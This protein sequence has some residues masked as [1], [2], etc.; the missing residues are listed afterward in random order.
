MKRLSRDP[1]RFDLI[2]VFAEYGRE[3]KVSL[4]N[5]NAAA[6]F[7]QRARASIDLSL[8]NDALLYGVR[9]E[10]MFEALVASLG[11]VEILKHEDAGEVYVS[12]EGLRIPDFRL[13]LSDGS[14]ILVEVKNFYQGKDARQDFELDR[15]YLQ[16]LIRYSKAMKCDPLVAIYWARWNIWTLVPTEAFADAGERVKIDM[17]DA[18]KANHMMKLGDYSVGT[19]FP[20]SLVLH[21]DKTKPRKVRA[22][23]EATFVISGVDVQCAGKSIANALERRIATFLMFYGRWMYE[24]KPQI[25]GGEIESVEHRWFPEEDHNQGFEIVGA[26][27]EMFCTFYKFATQ[28]ER[29]VGRL[30]IDVSPGS[31]GNLIPDDY[32]GIGLPLWR[33]RLEPSLSRAV[34][35]KID[36]K[37]Q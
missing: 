7:V 20:L 22:D 2:S 12:D 10:L 19:R 24:V 15:N 37:N 32:K 6:D 25:V 31:L 9:T 28:E 30:R 34:E 23:G 26:M 8:S 36:A 1:M 35:E 11:T 14:Q 33:F 18:M 17:L 13:V 29:Q 16:G 21:A 27:S 4:R 5:A 3:E